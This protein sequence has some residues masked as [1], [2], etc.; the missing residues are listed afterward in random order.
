MS[1]LLSFLLNIA[2]AQPIT[3]CSLYNPN[4]TAVVRATRN[5]AI[6]RLALAALMPVDEPLFRRALAQM[7]RGLPT[8]KSFGHETPTASVYLAPG[9]GSVPENLAF[10]LLRVQSQSVGS[11][12]GP[13][14]AIKDFLQSLREL[15]SIIDE[16]VM[17]P[18]DLEFA[19]KLMEAGHPEHKLMV[20]LLLKS[21]RQL[22]AWANP[23]S[24]TSPHPSSSLA[25]QTQSEHMAG[26]TNFL[27]SPRPLGPEK[28][29]ELLWE[30]AREKAIRALTPSELVESMAQSF[31]ERDKLRLTHLLQKVG[32]QQPFGSPEFIRRLSSLARAMV[33]PA[34]E[35]P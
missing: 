28:L 1:L 24:R 4:Y 32:T 2:S 16:K 10:A 7:A 30:I 26:W 11:Q 13:K 33:L 23:R 21:W 8:S 18:G 25:L 20:E 3:P 9:F 35:L 29:D 27:S 34:T 22:R 12:G 6:D 17:T 19:L 31:Y 14:G 15:K 5:V